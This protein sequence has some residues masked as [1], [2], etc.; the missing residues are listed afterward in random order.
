[1]KKINLLSSTYLIVITFLSISFSPVKSSTYKSKSCYTEFSFSNQSTS[2][3]VS[4]ISIADNDED[5][6]DTNVTPSSGFD[7]ALDVSSTVEIAI[8]LSSSHPA[9]RMNIFG[10]GVNVCINIPANSSQVYLYFLSASCDNRY[11]I[12]YN[13][14]TC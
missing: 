2:T 11:K 3:T 5:F 6:Y 8:Q 4:L 13:D 7:C 14:G 12:E 9:G 1:M 10:Y